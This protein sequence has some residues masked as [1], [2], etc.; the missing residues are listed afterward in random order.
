M[1]AAL[2]SAASGAELTADY[3]SE[4]CPHALTTIKVLVGAAILR[5]PRMG[6]SLVRLHFHDCFVN[7][8]DGSILLDDTDDMIG[9]KTARPNNN[10]VRGYDVIDTIKSAVNTV[11]LGNVVSCA[12]IV[13]VAARDSILGGT[14]YDVLLGRR[15]A[16][17]ASIDDA[18]NDIPTPFMD[19][20]ALQAN[21]ESHGLSLHDLVVLSGGHTLGY[22]KC[23][24]FR[25]RLYN[26]SDT[27]D[28]AYAASLDER[29]PLA[30]DD[31]ELSSLDDTPTTVDTDYYQGLI[32]G[33]ALLH[34]DQQLYQ[35][36]AGDLV[37]YYADNPAKF[38]EDFGAAMVKMGNLSPLTGDDGE[39]R[40]NCRVIDS[41]F[42]RSVCRP[43]GDPGGPPPPLRSPTHPRPSTSPPPEHAAGSP[44]GRK[45]GG[46]EA[47]IQTS[48]P[49]RWSSP[50]TTSSLASRLLHMELGQQVAGGQI[51]PGRSF[52]GDAPPPG[53]NPALLTHG[54]GPADRRRLDPASHP[55]TVAGSLQAPTSPPSIPS[56]SLDC[57]SGV[58][59]PGA[60]QRL[61]SP[62]LETLLLLGSRAAAEV[63]GGSPA[64]MQFGRELAGGG[65]AFLYMRVHDSCAGGG[66][67]MVSRSCYVTTA[68]PR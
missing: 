6:A 62:M 2:A 1:A 45:D 61:C 37:K 48:P 65:A 3:Y 21:F 44:C 17:A 29:C 26:E 34:S 14:S 66:A 15:D 19:L 10:S 67:P 35:G 63:D 68:R 33:R 38:W 22:S 57:F 20:P 11:C 53:S 56:L 18:N 46:G 40:E 59:C 39:V 7:G 50:N 60:P 9:E 23:A 13:A 12:D 55:L 32:N 41:N 52:P 64:R 42:I 43:S 25:S 30:G 58:R 5:E 8:C 36:D 24:F 49:A 54:S 51:R 16:T 27:L 4:T 28:A 47:S 31:D